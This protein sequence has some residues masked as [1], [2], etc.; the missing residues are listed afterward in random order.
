M[1]RCFVA[2]FMWKL[3]FYVRKLSPNFLYSDESKFTVHFRRTSKIVARQNSR[4]QL[5][6][7]CVYVNLNI[8]TYYIAKM[9][10]NDF[11][12]L[13]IITLKKWFIHIYIS[14]YLNVFALI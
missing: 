9:C 11:S 4:S 10:K 12:F 2:L 7:K 1:D 5:V 13:F 8:Q 6:Q 14:L 3:E